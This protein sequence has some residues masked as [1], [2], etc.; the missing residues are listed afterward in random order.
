MNGYHRVD[1]QCYAPSIADLTVW[2][3]T[4][5]H[6]KDEAFNHSNGDA[7]VWRFLWT[8]FAQYYHV[9][10]NGSEAPSDD[11]KPQ[12]DLVEWAQDKRAVWE[13][14]VDKYGGNADSFQMYGF[15]MMN[16]LF[17]PSTPGAPFMSTAL[18]ARRLGWDRIDDTYEAWISTF[19]SYENAGV[20]PGPDSV[21]RMGHSN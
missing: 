7:V 2:S 9:P 3:T 6:C 8:M 19:R 18:K 11:G 14:I 21:P 17:C 1:D 20:L 12:M 13:G 4:Q 16:W 10:M 5:D 15:A